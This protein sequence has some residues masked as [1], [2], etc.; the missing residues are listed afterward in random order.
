MPFIDR[1][2]LANKRLLQK[3]IQELY[4]SKGS[5]ESYEFLFRILYGLEAEVVFPGDNVIKPSVSE[6]SEPTVM[7]LFSTK[8]LTKYKKGQIKKITGSVVIASAYI[9]DASGISGTNDASN[10]YEL[11]LI[12]PHVGTFLPGDT[13]VLSD[14]DGLRTDAEATVRGVMSDISTTESSLYVGLED[15]S[16]GTNEDTIRVCLLYTSPS[17]RDRG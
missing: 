17:P 4:L 13:V 3:H 10:A 8:D 2:V 11:E 15:G 5:K 7:R 12:L 9:N 6:F 1:D 16:A 14:R